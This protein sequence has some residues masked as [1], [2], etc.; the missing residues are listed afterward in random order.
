MPTSRL[1]VLE[2]SDYKD[3]LRQSHSTPEAVGAK[4]QAEPFD[5]NIVSSE[6]PADPVTVKDPSPEPLEEVLVE[7]EEEKK[8]E[9]F[10]VKAVEDLPAPAQAPAQQLLSQLSRIPA[11]SFHPITGQ[12]SLHG[13]PL[14]YTLNQLLAST[15]RAGAKVDVPQSLINF[16]RQNGINKLRNKKI[17][18]S[19]KHTWRNLYSSPVST[20]TRKILAP[21]EASKR[22]SRLQKTA[23]TRKSPRRTSKTFFDPRVPTPFIAP[24]ADFTPGTRL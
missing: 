13:Q 3:L 5:K 2:E 24:P 15:C 18:L 19:Q 1:I 9:K 20:M 4:N 6:N 8:E 10:S 22:S 14:D 7:E 21:T 11:F 17:R 23:D 12:I 16:L